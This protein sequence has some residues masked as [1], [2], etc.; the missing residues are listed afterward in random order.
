MHDEFKL[1]TLTSSFV[2]TLLNAMGYTFVMLLFVLYMLFETDE[3]SKADPYFSGS[4][5]SAA[6]MRKQIDEQIQR[7]ITIKTI[8]SATVGVIVYV[9]LGPILQVKMA[10]LFAV[11][12]FFANFIPNV[13]AVIGMF[14][15]CC[16]MN[17]VKF[18]L[19]DVV[20]QYMLY[21]HFFTLSRL[22]I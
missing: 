2:V 1:V 19:F 3:D 11:L 5:S 6:S 18:S 10:H 17:H 4:M 9:C 16:F 7:Y 20:I 8:I 12:T 22:T 13:G 14:V 15:C 21:T